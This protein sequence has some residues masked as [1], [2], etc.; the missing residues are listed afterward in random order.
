MTEGKVVL[1]GI[2]GIERPQRLRDLAGHLPPGTRIFRQPETSP[3]S[4]HARVQRNDQLGGGDSRPDS[5]IN[6]IASDHPAKKQV[7]QFA[8]AAARRFGKEIAD[9]ETIARSIPAPAIGL[10]EIDGLRPY[11]E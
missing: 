8:S 5:E 2:L 10:V 4:D 7:Q 3:D 11:G 9:P 1:H 6:R